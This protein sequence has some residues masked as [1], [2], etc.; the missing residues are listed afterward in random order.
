[1]VAAEELGR[2]CFM[3]EKEP[4]YVDI[5]LRRISESLGSSGKRAIIERAAASA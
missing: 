2:R 4:K 5:A 3:M 1:M